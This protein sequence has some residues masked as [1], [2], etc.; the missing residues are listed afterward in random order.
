MKVEPS[1]MG[2]VPL[3][4]GSRSSHCGAAEMNPTSIHEDVG[5]T[6]CS[7]GIPR[8]CGCGGGYSSD[9]TPSLGSLCDAGVALKK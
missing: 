2:S 3:Q 7:L 4:R 5:S 9:S 1:Q 6:P 8:C